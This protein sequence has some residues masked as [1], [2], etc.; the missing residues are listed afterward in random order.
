MVPVSTPAEMVKVPVVA[1]KSA[2]CAAVPELEAYT[3][4]TSSAGAA[5]NETVKVAV[6]SDSFRVTFSM[7][8][9]GSSS[10]LITRSA[11]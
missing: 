8:T 2:F 1:V 6:P 9:K 3:T 4:V 7:L 5:S 11:V 10:S